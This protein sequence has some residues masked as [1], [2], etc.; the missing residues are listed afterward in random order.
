MSSSK[1]AAAITSF[2]DD[3]DDD[4]DIGDAND[5]AMHGRSIVLALE[6]DFAATLSGKQS[7]PDIP[8]Y[9]PDIPCSSASE[10]MPGGSYIDTRSI[11][12]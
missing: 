10:R 1:E 3:D 7:I 12:R 2:N 4:D 8:S 11:D 6:P 9:Y 5:D